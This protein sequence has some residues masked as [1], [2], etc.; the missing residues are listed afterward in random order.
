MACVPYAG[1]RSEWWRNAAALGTWMV[2]AV[3]TVAAVLDGRFGGTRALIW[4]AA[5]L[6]FGAALIPCLGLCRLPSS[7]VL[8]P[9]LLTLQGAA[10]L[11]MV[12]TSGNGTA[13][14]TLVIVA[15]EVASYYSA[16]VTWLAVTAQSLGLMIV[17][18]RLDSVTEAVAGAGAFAGFQAFAVTTVL[19]AERER[20]AREGLAR[21]HAELL[22]TR[23]LLAENS[24]MSERVRIARDLHDTLGHHLTA[25]SLQ[26]DV[27]S[28]LTS[29]PA[30]AHVEEAHAIARLLLSDVRNVVSEMRDSQLDL[31]AAVQA[32]A[33]MPGP[34]RIHLDM[35]ASLD[36][37]DAGQAQALLRG[38]QEIITNASRHAAARNLWIRIVASAKAIELHARDDGRGAASVTWGNGLKGMRERFQEHAGRVDVTTADGRGF[39]V[40]GVMPR[41]GAV[42]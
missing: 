41:T 22:A 9:A 16:R 24:R 38:V 26:L 15:A 8:V 21:A 13:A 10:G 19:L 1:T 32:L 39:E 25:L 20:A 40:R 2:V 7:R 17:W 37:E 12:A 31:A 6:A 18:A 28:R 27:A 36:V 11:T 5:F 3:P 33:G 23:A 4:A 30:A 35:P 14:A 42:S 29:G 34:L